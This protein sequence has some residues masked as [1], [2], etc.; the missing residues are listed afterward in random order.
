MRFYTKIILLILLVAVM[1]GGSSFLLANRL[2]EKE[3]RA[4]LEEKGKIIAQ[5]L[6]EHV[7]QHVMYGEM[8]LVR[9]AL[10]A[11]VKNNDDVEYAFVY[12]KQVMSLHTFNKGVPQGLLEKV[13]AH[14]PDKTYH[15]SL[16]SSNKGAIL[17]IGIPI[18]AGASTYVHIGLNEAT[19][20]EQ[21]SSLRPQIILIIFI[22]VLFSTAIGLL[23]SR[24]MIIPLRQLT[25]AIKA[26][27]AKTDFKPLKTITGGK[28]V[29]E[30]AGAFQK[31]VSERENIEKNLHLSEERYA[32]AQKA[33]NIGSWDWNIQTG[34]LHWSEQIEPIFGFGQDEF[35]R[36]YEAFLESVHP[37]DRQYVIDS[38]N[39]AIEKDEEYDI[40]HRIIW[41]SGTVRWVSEKG[42]VFHDQSGKPIRMLG[43]VYDITKRKAIEKERERLI[44]ELKKALAEIRTLRG[45]LPICCSCKKIRDDKGY[46]NQIESYI[47][48]HADVEF[49]HSICPDC[50]RKLYPEEY[51]SM[52]GKNI[53]K[54]E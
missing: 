41:P 51:S 13:S 1:F 35:G 50:A 40:E 25:A 15:T 23:L 18:F 38:V 21:V 16:I 53:S 30:L 2:M 6:T 4:S 33:A 46:W 12:D 34:E 24:Q 7:A 39:V 47:H 27:G 48:K 9:D 14:D 5:S 22:A 54:S 29:T 19:I 31:M 43:T 8:L 28:E 44:G 37:D 20:H 3:L 11:T 32:M 17:D 45:F 52:Y 49:S 42:D 26:F 36:T 10:L